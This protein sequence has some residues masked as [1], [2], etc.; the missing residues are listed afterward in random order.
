MWRKRPA[1][2]LTMLA[3]G[4][5]VGGG[6]YAAIPSSNG[7]IQACITRERGLIRAIDQEAGEACSATERP[8]SWNQVGPPGPPG[9]PGA[10]SFGEAVVARSPIFL[11]PSGIQEVN[12][13]IV[14][15][16]GSYL[17]WAGTNIHNQSSVDANAG[18]EVWRNG[19]QL[20]SQIVGVGPVESEDSHA[21]LSML[22]WTETIPAGTKIWMNCWSN[23]SPVHMTSN[24]M[25]ALRVRGVTTQFPS[26]P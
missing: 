11:V 4:L 14:P 10:T 20:S 23:Y 12:S 15:E 18:C 7:T 21:A 19:S 26:V 13:L 25:I 8:L 22:G 2:V 17:V 16:S 24:Q 6:V 5:V 9:E 1:I 3:V